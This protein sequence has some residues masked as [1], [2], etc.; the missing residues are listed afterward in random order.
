MIRFREKA[1][2]VVSTAALCACAT[3]QP[4]LTQANHTAK[5]MSQ[6]EIQLDDFRAVA[7]AAEQARLAAMSTQRASTERV[8][9]LARLDV[10]TKQSAG[11]QIEE[12]MRQKL[13]ADA[14]FI[15]ALEPGLAAARQADQ[16]E[17][18][19]LLAPLPATAKDM[20]AAQ[21]A[22]A[23]M[24]T[25]LPLATRVDE[26]AGAVKDI[27]NAVRDNEHKIAA[28]KAKATAGDAATAAATR[29]EATAATDKQ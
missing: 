1:F 22:A 11:D 14:D 6:L 10:V 12:P 19:A 2:V 18:A 25:E 15:G 23:R 27:R 13:L 7:S 4:A 16:L 26:L 9:A 3:P 21:A 28:A 17:F 5:L 29:V 8:E 24:G 20:T